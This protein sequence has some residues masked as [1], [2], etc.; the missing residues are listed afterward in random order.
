MIEES[1]YYVPEIEELKLKDIVDVTSLVSGWRKG[2]CEYYIPNEDA[3][4]NTQLEI[5]DYLSFYGGDCYIRC[6]YLNKEDI[7]SLKWK[8]THEN[9][10]K[11]NVKESFTNTFYKLNFTLL[12]EIPWLK[13]VLVIPHGKSNTTENQIFEGK[14]KNI[15]EF[16][17]LMEQLGIK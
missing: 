17:K 2:E 12:G 13:I 7:E 4:F 9:E 6:K 16:E 3:A 15:N 11:Y 5:D 1:R 8:H 14:V 10:F